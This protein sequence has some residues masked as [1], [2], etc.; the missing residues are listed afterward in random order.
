LNSFCWKRASG[1]AL[2]LALANRRQWN[3]TGG[4]R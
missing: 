4:L 1:D 3:N 2:T